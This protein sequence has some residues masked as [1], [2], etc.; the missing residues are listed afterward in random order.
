MG[1]K[2]FSVSFLCLLCF[3]IPIRSLKIVFCDGTCKKEEGH[4]RLALKQNPNVNSKPGYYR[5][6]REAAFLPSFP[7]IPLAISDTEGLKSPD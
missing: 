4:L 6:A 3:T 7:V 2:V 5:A 1:D